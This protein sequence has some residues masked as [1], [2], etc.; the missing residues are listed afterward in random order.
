MFCIFHGL[1]KKRAVFIFMFIFEVCFIRQIFFFL[2]QTFQYHSYY[3]LLFCYKDLCIVFILDD[4][5]ERSVFA[6]NPLKNND[7]RNKSVSVCFR[8]RIVI[9]SH[10]LHHF[11]DL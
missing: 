2:L 8:E 5:S 6:I 10:I 9:Q 11:S 4:S 1:K 3:I 7:E